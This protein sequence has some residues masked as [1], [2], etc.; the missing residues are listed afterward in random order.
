M[1]PDLPTLEKGKY[2]HTKSGKYYEVLGVSLHSETHEPL[3]VYRPLY[4]TKYE[5]FATTI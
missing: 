5:L 4:D 2:L 1:D 3:V